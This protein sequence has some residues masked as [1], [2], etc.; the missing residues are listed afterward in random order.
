MITLQACAY[1]EAGHAVIGYLLGHSA[2]RIHIGMRGGETRLYRN[3]GGRSRT[4]TY[5]PLIKRKLPG[6]LGT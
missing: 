6:D 4:R 3:T 2:K 5:D 1:H